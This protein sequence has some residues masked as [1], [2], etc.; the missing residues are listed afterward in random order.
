M[1]FY[2]RNIKVTGPEAKDR[3]ENVG[4]TSYWMVLS[5]KSIH[6]GPCF[7]EAAAQNRQMSARMSLDIIYSFIEMEFHV[8]QAGLKLIV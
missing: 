5:P 1:L 7:F 4:V 8:Y 6:W 3:H 2:H